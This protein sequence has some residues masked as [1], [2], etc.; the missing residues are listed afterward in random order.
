MKTN[1]KMAIIVL[2]IGLIGCNSDQAEIKTPNAIKQEVSHTHETDN[3][4]F[5][6]HQIYV[7]GEV[8][9]PLELTVDSLKEMDVVTIENFAVVCQ[10]GAT[11]KTDSISKGVL[12]RD[13]LDKATIIQKNHKDRNF[14]IVARAS[15]G[16][17]ATFSWA[18]IYNNEV[19][20]GVYVL[21][22][23]NGLSI[24]EKG[25]M[26]LISKSDIKTGP[27]H[28]FWLSSIEVNKVE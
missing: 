21:F 24:K 1:Q 9:C 10:S 12:L 17:K 27:R 3:E 28:V 7:K 11:T 23:E 5:I 15:D 8:E 6:R 13:I 2:T 16:Y 20:N 4:A 18:E 25:D 14:Y 19:G 22:E 26:I